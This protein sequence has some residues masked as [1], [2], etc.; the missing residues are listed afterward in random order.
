MQFFGFC[1]I[2]LLSLEI[3]AQEPRY[4]GSFT[5]PHHTSLVSVHAGDVDGNGKLALVATTAG[6]D[7][8]EVFQSNEMCQCAANIAGAN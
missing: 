3:S 8:A 2:L 4:R 6:Q 5:I 1:G 7:V